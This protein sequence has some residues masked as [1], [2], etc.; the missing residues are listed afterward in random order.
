MKIWG[1]ADKK[2]IFT[3]HY[4]RQRAALDLLV[5]KPKNHQFT[6]RTT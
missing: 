3:A 6:K 1:Y 5:L 2:Y 4:G